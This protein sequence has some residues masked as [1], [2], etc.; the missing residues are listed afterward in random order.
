MIEHVLVSY[1]LGLYPATSVPLL[2]HHFYIIIFLIF[3][4]FYL[5][6][7]CPVQFSC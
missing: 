1:D 3:Y 2:S 7:R 5:R 4:Q 6:N